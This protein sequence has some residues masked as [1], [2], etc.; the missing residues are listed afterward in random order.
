[1]D[2]VGRKLGQAGG[3]NLQ[4]YLTDVGRFA[5]KHQGD[6]VLGPAVKS[7]ALAAEALGGTA[8][9][10]LTWFQTG[11]IAMV[12]LHANRFL[13]MM[14][15]TTV[16]WMLLEGAAIGQENKKSKGLAAGHP[17][18]A[19]YDGKVAAA[20]YYAR[21]VLPGVEYKAKLMADEDK[22]P[23]EITDASFATV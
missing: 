8:M 16:A 6:A 12:P 3:A 7:L 1:M 21:N 14:S 17:E 4:A 23:L 15:E 20:L 18:A 5:Q 22:S 13:E 19:F 10:L 9:R 11:N 2:L